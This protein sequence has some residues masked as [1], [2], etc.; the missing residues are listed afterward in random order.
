M[1]NHNES[2]NKITRLKKHFDKIKLLNND[3]THIFDNLKTKTHKLKDIYK[4][5]L[6]ENRN[7]LF[8]FGLD[9]FKFQNRLIDEELKSL[10]RYYNLICNRIY[11]D[12]YKLYQLVNK[13][14]NDDESL[15]KMHKIKTIQKYEKYDYLNIYKHYDIQR[16]ADIFSDILSLI[17]SLCDHSKSEFN[18]IK[19]Y[20]N[21][22]QF[23]L[24]INNFI[25]T[26]MYKNTILNEQI[27]LYLNYLSFF[28][29]LHL[30]YFVRFISKIK[31][32]YSQVN[33][34]I[35]FENTE[36]DR[37]N[38]SKKL[39]LTSSSNSLLSDS[40]NYNQIIKNNEI[41]NNIQI[42][43]S[44]MFNHT[45]MNTND[46]ISN[47]FTLT[48]DNTEDMSNN[49]VINNLIDNE[50]LKI[51]I[52]SPIHNTSQTLSEDNSFVHLDT[53]HYDNT[54]VNSNIVLSNINKDG[55]CYNSDENSDTHS[56]HT[57]NYENEEYT[58]E[59]KKKTRRGKKRK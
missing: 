2:I 8:I 39:V 7:T 48:K 38:Y 4:N 43:N 55:F 40:D 13:Y 37:H 29:E 32:I 44:N 18:I 51:D 31:L 9:T 12:Y 15:E 54:S 30:K 59:Q 56:I 46:N 20:N 25:Y 3:I 49:N 45:Q 57:H 16:S 36:N 14:I 22:K 26:H 58:K 41:E 11:C 52:I 1:S 53:I 19:S 34:D 17:I 28:I 5:F 33:K 27:S 24:N 47:N 42:S 35:D 23:G 10:D 50:N 21:K 6:N